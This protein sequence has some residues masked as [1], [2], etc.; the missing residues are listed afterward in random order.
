MKEVEYRG[1]AG[2]HYFSFDRDGKI[3]VQ[4][5]S[6]GLEPSKDTPRMSFALTTRSLSASSKTYHSYVDIYILEPWWERLEIGD[7]LFISYGIE[8]WKIPER[9]ADIAKDYL[10]KATLA[11][12]GLIQNNDNFSTVAERR[13]NRAVVPIVNLSLNS[14]N[15]FF[16]KFN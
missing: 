4:H 7:E 5:L 12:P 3:P 10:Q 8:Y 14:S 1:G 16:F 6:N 9:M 13:S 15:A 2:V 11:Y